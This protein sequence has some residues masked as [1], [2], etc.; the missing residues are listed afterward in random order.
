[1]GS[2]TR[3]LDPTKPNCPSGP[4]G[5]TGPPRRS[6]PTSSRPGARNR[7]NWPNWPA[8]GVGPDLGRARGPEPAELARSAGS[9]RASHG[10][11]C[12]LSTSVWW[13]LSSPSH[14]CH[15]HPKCQF[16]MDTNIRGGTKNQCLPRKATPPKGENNATQKE[17]RTT[18]PPKRT[19]LENSNIQQRRGMATRFKE[20]E[21]NSNAQKEQK[22]AKKAASSLGW[23]GAFSTS[24][25]GC[26]AAVL[27]WVVLLPLVAA[28]S[29]PFFWVVL[30]FLEKKNKKH[31]TNETN[32]KNHKP[33]TYSKKL[34]TSNS[35]CILC[36]NDKD[37][38]SQRVSSFRI[39]VGFL[40]LQQPSLPWHPI[41]SH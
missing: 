37:N 2:C 28:F 33:K 34:L 7:P 24:F 15:A 39:F 14:V 30:F 36:K 32:Q 21:K 1:M 26:G 5:P 38:E 3:K 23:C 6:D 40:S 10:W 16:T 35:N 20:M 25:F 9:D 31:T 11:C 12:L 41:T 19:R 29:S 18:A 22:K 17:R 27:P 4:T 13:C 8:P